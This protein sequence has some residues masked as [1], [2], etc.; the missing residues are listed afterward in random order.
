[1]DESLTKIRHE[2]SKKDFPALSLRDDEYVEFAFKRAQ[3]CLILILAGTAFGV[4]VVLL[5]FLLT[6][7]GQ[8]M[9]DE[10]GNNFLFL[11]LFTLLSVTIIVSIVSLIVYR[12]NRLFVTNRR[13]IQI[14]MSSLVS[15]SINAIDLKSIEDVSFHQ[16]G[17]LQRLFHFGTLRLATVGDET[18]Y[19]FKYS[20]ISPDTLEALSKLITHAKESAKLDTDSK[21]S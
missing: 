20:S 15:T 18:T 16:A 12:N 10:M 2:R 6:L 17:I 13:V 3:A 5:A 1:M 7:L 11:I 14:T 21:N 4:I 19:T 8:S 9:L